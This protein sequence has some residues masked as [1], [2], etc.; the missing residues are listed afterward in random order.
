M[1]FSP[2]IARLCDDIAKCS[3]GCIT[4]DDMFNFLIT[5][6]ANNL[7]KILGI[8]AED[9]EKI[10]ENVSIYT[11]SGG[12]GGDEGKGGITDKMVDKLKSE[13]NKVYLLSPNGGAGA[14]HTT[15]KLKH[16]IWVKHNTNIFP[17]SLAN[18]DVVFLGH[19]KLLNL[20]SLVDEVSRITDTSNGTQLLTLDELLK[21]VRI[22]NQARITFLPAIIQEIIN[23]Y[24]KSLSHGGKVGT[25]LQGISTTI[26][27]YAIKLPIEVLTYLNKTSEELSELL[28]EYYK[29]GNFDSVF[30]QYL[31]LVNDKII[32][33][34]A[35]T[36]N[37]EKTTVHGNTLDE[38][39]NVIK[40]IDTH[41]LTKFLDTFG[42]CVIGKDKIFD[43]IMNDVK[44]N[45][46][47]ALVSEGVQS[48][49]LA[50]CNGPLR[51]T[52]SSDLDL[53]NLMKSSL[54]LRAPLEAYMACGVKTTQV[55]ACKLI[56]SSVGN[57]QNVSLIHEYSDILKPNFRNDDSEDVKNIL[58]SNPDI[59][60]YAKFASIVLKTE[61]EKE[62]TLQNFYD[63]D[64]GKFSPAKLLA[65]YLAEFGTTSGRVR[66]LSWFDIPKIKHNLFSRSKQSY[67]YSRIDTYN[68]FTKFR[69][70][71]GYKSKSDGSI[72]SHDSQGVDF[73]TL[74]FDD[75]EPIYIELPTWEGTFDFEQCEKFED[76]PPE[77]KKMIQTLE[78][79]LGITFSCNLSA[80]TMI[81][82]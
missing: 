1:S 75:L 82:V 57:H 80:K 72:L 44:A 74:N 14:G 46:K 79:Y 64:S 70:C 59:G 41:F 62:T 18:A 11:F 5:I 35:V 17:A 40:Q 26:A 31:K 50:S 10:I 20:K 21:K 51:S 39:K 68:L 77:A 4:T 76:F 48:N 67:A 66:N 15:Y 3:R 33:P 60:Q 71:T 38:L 19:Q 34:I 81:F 49:G 45:I 22:S 24:A 32:N 12:Q 69:I 27:Q 78:T 37:N 58:E 63:S 53:A 23:E 55:I 65:Y 42:H 30:E 13:K 6:N 43:H 29:C 25:T 54:G 47:I 56:Q 8:D 61:K 36:I 28:N 52:T 2:D 7:S 16:G 9:A 73:K